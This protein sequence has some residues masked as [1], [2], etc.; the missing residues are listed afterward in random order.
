MKEFNGDLKG[1]PEEVVE[2][3][4]ERQVEQGNKRDVS[5]FEDSRRRDSFCGGFRWVETVEGHVF[6][7]SVISDKNFDIFFQHYPKQQQQQQPTFPCVMWV[8]Y[9]DIEQAIE[10]VVVLKT[11]RG[12]L[13]LTSIST[14]DDIDEANMATIWPNASFSDPRTKRVTKADAEEALSKQFNQKVEIV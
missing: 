6:W 14:L 2:K 10:L 13:A 1:F 8:W 4:L 9:T 5:V 7:K 12:Y 3:M 11:K